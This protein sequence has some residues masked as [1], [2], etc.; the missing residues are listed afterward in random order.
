MHGHVNEAMSVVRKA[1]GHTL[2]FAAFRAIGLAISFVS[3]PVLTRQLSV[4]EYGSLALVNASMTMLA[5]IA[6]CGLGMAMLR[7]FPTAQSDPERQRS[8]VGAAFGGTLAIWLVI[9]GVYLLVVSRYVQAAAQLDVL[10]TSLVA[11]MAASSALNDLFSALLRARD[12][13]FRSS[14]FGTGMTV[15]SVSC[16]LL[17]LAFAERKLLAF[18]AGSVGAELCILGIAWG[19]ELLRGRI[20]LGRAIIPDARVLFAFG[21]PLVL[22]EFSSLAMNQI[23]RFQ[24]AHFIGLDS[25]GLYSVGYNIATYAQ[26]LTTW[27]MWMALY[28]IYTR[29]W[30]TEGEQAV[31]RFLSSCTHA[32]MAASCAIVMCAVIGSRDAIQILASEKFAPAATVLPIVCAALMVNGMT[33]L[34][35]AGFYLKRNTAALAAIAACGAVL[36]G[37]LN[38]WTVPAFGIVGAALSTL[39]IYMTVTVAIALIGRRMLAV[40]WSALRLLSYVGA[41][42]AVAWLALRIQIANP[43]WELIARGALALPLYLAL[44]LAVDRPLREFVIST[45]GRR[46]R[47][48]D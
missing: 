4:S 31:S 9:A 29:L 6:K 12:Q 47:R 30:E 7:Q 38:L 46:P 8:L 24:I 43:W 41:A 14:L 19:R 25:V 44:V 28:P 39:A 33:H 15:A 10:L 16:G 21:F 20:Q 40:H 22:F 2:I 3:F 5:A 23:D 27:P 11:V 17:C 35:G 34:L 13:V 32:L 1:F 36:K 48:A 42:A 37:L 18:C 26:T 45:F